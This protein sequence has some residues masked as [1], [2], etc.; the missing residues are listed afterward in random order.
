VRFPLSVAFIVPVIAAS[1]GIIAL[2]PTY[3]TLVYV[4]LI[5]LK[6]VNLSSPIEIILPK[7]AF[8]TLLLVAAVVLL[9]ALLSYY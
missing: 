3:D 5:G 1:G 7:T 9:A 4:L 8:E 6:L 2:L